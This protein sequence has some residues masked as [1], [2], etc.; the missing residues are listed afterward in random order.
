M[1]K[2]S[3]TVR[4]D[5]DAPGSEDV[6]AVSDAMRIPEPDRTNSLKRTVFR[7]EAHS[8]SVGSVRG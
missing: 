4:N 5:G 1:G 3:N 7:C 2:G 8:N 6:S